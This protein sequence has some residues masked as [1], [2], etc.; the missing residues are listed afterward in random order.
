M[1]LDSADNSAA[2]AEGDL[3]HGL[4]PEQVVAVPFHTSSLLSRN[5]L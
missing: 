5:E 2:P 4:H 3:A 1:M